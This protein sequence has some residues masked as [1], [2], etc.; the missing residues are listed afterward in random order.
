[1]RK[2][3][4]L[5]VFVLIL[6]FSTSVYGKCLPRDESYNKYVKKTY[7]QNSKTIKSLKRYLICHKEKE[8]FIMLAKAYEY[9]QKYYLAGLAYKDA[10]EMI[11]LGLRQ[12]S[13]VR[14]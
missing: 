14:I 8:V 3:I 10:G 4:A 12:N 2:G 7:K 1:M 6:L 5:T 11:K 13:W 9:D